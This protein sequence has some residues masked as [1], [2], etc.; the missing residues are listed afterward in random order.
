MVAG[1]RRGW[2]VILLTA[3]FS[4][5]REDGCESS[6]AYSRDRDESASLVRSPRRHGSLLI[7]GSG[8]AYYVIGSD[9]QALLTPRPRCSGN[10]F[11][12]ERDL[13]FRVSPS[14]RTDSFDLVE[15]LALSS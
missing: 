4:Q 2:I 14:I 10:A 1:P 15:R 6:D 9:S 5:G 3:S 7:D 12:K 11:I 13:S 8:E